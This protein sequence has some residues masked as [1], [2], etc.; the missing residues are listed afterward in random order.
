MV[1]TFP[2]GVV[3]CSSWV[4]L[5]KAVDA[6]FVS[7]AWT[8]TGKIT[9]TQHKKNG[10]DKCTLQR[11][12]NN[13]KNWKMAQDS[14]PDFQSGKSQK[15]KP[16]DLGM[17]HRHSITCQF[18]K[19]QVKT[20]QTQHAYR[21]VHTHTESSQVSNESNHYPQDSICPLPGHGTGRELGQ[22]ARFH[23]FRAQP[24]L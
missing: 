15:S 8:D 6:M 13:L 22:T 16:S 4:G 5:T 24:G 14:E 12:E 3:D 18:K 7:R 23:P 1:T 9:Q 17:P 21:R 2:G 20:K 19:V 11:S 10:S